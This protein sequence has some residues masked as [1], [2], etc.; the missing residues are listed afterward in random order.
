MPCLT[1]CKLLMILAFMCILAG[2]IYMLFIY[3]ITS[4]CLSTWLDDIT[5]LNKRTV[6]S[7]QVDKVSATKEIWAD[8]HDN[9]GDNL[10]ARQTDKAANRYQEVWKRRYPKPFWSAFRTSL[11]GKPLN[12]IYCFRGQYMEPLRGKMVPRRQTAQ[13]RFAEDL[14]VLCES[15]CWSKPA[16]TWMRIADLGPCFLVV[17]NW[18]HMKGSGGKRQVSIF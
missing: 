4:L 5:L 17:A 1:G 11:V 3:F 16:W 13:W 14:A 12:V 18:W 10:V 9:S 7:G 2:L 8:I 15:S 6:W